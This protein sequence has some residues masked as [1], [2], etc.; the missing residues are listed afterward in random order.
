M[1]GA[2]TREDRAFSTSS[3]VTAYKQSNSN[4]SSSSSINAQGGRQ[5]QQN[6]VDNKGREGC[7]PSPSMSDVW[8]GS[9]SSPQKRSIFP[10]EMACFGAF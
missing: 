8:G 4:S 9:M 5:V 3:T 2:T 7:I 1:T 10:L 6:E